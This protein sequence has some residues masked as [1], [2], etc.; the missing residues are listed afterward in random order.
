MRHDRPIFLR[1]RTTGG[2]SL[3]GMPT[4]WIFQQLEQNAEPFWPRKLSCNSHI[5]QSLMEAL[6]EESE[7]RLTLAS[8]LHFARSVGAVCPRLEDMDRGIWRIYLCSWEFT[9]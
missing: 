3:E 6:S 9:G 4:T 5:T 7:K 1:A 8:Y 2:S